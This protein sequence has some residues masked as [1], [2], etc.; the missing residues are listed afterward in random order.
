LPQWKI[1]TV[2]DTASSIKGLAGLFRPDPR[3][4][5]KKPTLKKLLVQEPEQTEEA[6]HTRTRA[7]RAN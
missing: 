3:A 6:P 7:T 1:R 2:E 4:F 5:E